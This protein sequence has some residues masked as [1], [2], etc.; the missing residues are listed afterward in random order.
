MR[1]QY[2]GSA[3]TLLL[4]LRLRVRE[5]VCVR[6]RVRAGEATNQR[7]ALAIMVPSV[8]MQ[9]YTWL[10][11]YTRTLSSLS[12]NIHT[13][14]IALFLRPFSNEDGCAL[15]LLLHPRLRCDRAGGVGLNRV[16]DEYS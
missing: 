14:T 11:T 5:C 12:Y 4:H 7:W 8:A 1:M 16:P 13:L 3:L 10:H 15:T 9:R 6:V 2:L